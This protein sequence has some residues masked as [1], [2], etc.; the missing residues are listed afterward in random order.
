MCVRLS[1]ENL[2]N[3]IE[4]VI[5]SDLSDQRSRSHKAFKVGSENTFNKLFSKLLLLI[6]HWFNSSTVLFGN[7]FGCVWSFILLY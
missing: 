5:S 3:Y 2:R 7:Y 1:K 6:K 4:P